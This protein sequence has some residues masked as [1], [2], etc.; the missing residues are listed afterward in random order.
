MNYSEKLKDPRWQQMRLKVFERDSWTCRSCQ[1]SGHTLHAHH[2]YYEHGRDP[3]DYPLDT[4]ITLCESCH[5]EESH[6]RPK[7][8]ADLLFELRSLF[9]SDE[10]ACL[11]RGFKYLE[12]DGDHEVLACAI[13]YAL[14]N[15]EIVNMIIDK[16]DEYLQNRPNPFTNN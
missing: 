16:W 3:W 14:S 5:E 2:K 13:E 1:D 10:V 15:R 6:C 11:S 4:L 8:E 12:Y 9:M 7:S